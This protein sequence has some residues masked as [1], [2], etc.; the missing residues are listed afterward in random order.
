MLEAWSTMRTH[1]V[2]ETS[3]V[4]H[5]ADVKWSYSIEYCISCRFQGDASD[6]NLISKDHMH[7]D[8]NPMMHSK[9]A[10][11]KKIVLFINHN[12]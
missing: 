5:K 4:G 12:Y 8:N 11:K 9:N 6:S 3:K 1:A 10:E 2:Q 7:W